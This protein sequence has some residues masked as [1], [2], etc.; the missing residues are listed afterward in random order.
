MFPAPS[1][2]A[3]IKILTSLTIRQDG[4][5]IVGPKHMDPHF[6]YWNL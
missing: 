5:L 2:L 4:I 6:E 1:H 3:K